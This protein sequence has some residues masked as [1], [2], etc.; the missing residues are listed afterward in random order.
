MIEYRKRQRM[1]GNGWDVI[2]PYYPLCIDS[3]LDV[4][5]ETI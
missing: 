2:V 4:S 3:T 1:E 5:L